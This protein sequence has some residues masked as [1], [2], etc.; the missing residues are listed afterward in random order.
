MAA[1]ATQR[2]S[3][4]VVG[5]GVAG[6]TAAY[7]LRRTDEVTLYEADDRLG[8]HAHTHDVTGGDGTVRAVDSGFIVHNARTYPLLRRLFRE[9][10]VATRPSEMSMSVR[11]EG[12]G[13]EYAGAKGAHGLLARPRQL[14]RARYLRMLG[15]IPVF[16]RR[17]RRLLTA[18]TYKDTR[19]AREA[20]EG[21]GE[22]ELT[23]GGFLRRHGFSAYFTTHFMVP[24]IS[25]VWSCAPEDALHYPARY[26]FRFLAH[27]GMLSIGGSPSWRT[28][29]GGS[30]EY[31]AR[32]AARLDA[33][34]T[35]TPVRSVL[36]HHDRH[37]GVE[38]VTADGA[39]RAHD[40]V[41]LAV[42]ADQA[43]GLL[44]DPTAEEREVLGAFRYSRSAA[45]LHTDA[46][47]LPR[48]RGARASWNYL[49]PSCD[50]GAD[51]V[52]VSYHM[53]RLQRLAAPDDY[54]VT[55]GA[56]DRVEPGAVLA[57]TAYEHPLY[58]TESVAAQERLPRLSG[59]ST[60]YAGAYHGWGFH[61]DGC[62]SGVRAAE[63][64]GVS[65]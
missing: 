10:G 3:T 14:A 20:R 12:C 38:L 44:A 9:L 53:N 15:E 30:R 17:A 19:E 37:D 63:A 54:V 5:S 58:T 55:L 23:L 1:M 21:T 35:S 34:H 50:T 8:G 40:A 32:I 4:A 7:L 16:H 13:L 18:G 48:S 11:C 28:V 29:A 33:V 65:W 26:L 24:L 46:A 27:H 42:H 41:V 52:R 64:L 25:A 57:N 47:L 62:R 51:R 60:A 36:R 31:V 61:E 56:G 39:A 43:L 45:S 2:R 59:G 6:L 22:G 49:M